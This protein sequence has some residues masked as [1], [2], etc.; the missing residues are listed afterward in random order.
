MSILSSV[1]RPSLVLLT[2]LYELTMA[3]GYW[4]EGMREQEATF[5][6]LFRTLPFEGGFAVACG[7]QQAVEFLQQL[8][9]GEDDLAYL[10]ELPGADGEPLFSAE[11]LAY[12]RELRFTCD[13]D[14]VPEGTVV[15]PQEPLI[16][17]RGPIIQA[18]IVETALLT[19][20]NFQT[21]IATKAAR[22]CLAAQ[23]DP[24][25]EFGLRRAQGVD[26][27]LS[28]SRAAFVGGCA[29]TSNLLAGKLFGIPVRGTHAHSWVMSFDSELEAFD[30]YA[31]ALP[32]NVVFL[33]DTY[34]TLE[35]V[36]HA[37][38]VGRRLRERGHE[39]LGIRLDSGDLAYLSKQ[40]RAILDEAGFAD[41]TILASSELDENIITSL[42]LQGATIAVWGVGTQLV[43]AY[44]QPA[45]GG[46]YKL[47][48][49]RNAGEPWEE[50]IKLSEQSIKITTPGILSVRRFSAGGEFIGDMIYDERFPPQGEA[51][52]VDPLDMT[53]RKHFPPDARCEELLVPAFRGGA[54]VYDA[55]PLEEVR[56]RAQEQ[57]AGFHEGVKRF[58]NPHRYPVGLEFELHQRR[59][60][61]I[62]AAR[63]EL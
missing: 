36:R 43:T 24:V 59:T 41:T 28:A 3:Y 17:V 40:A 15:F 46:V 27:G 29:A 1:Y 10:A 49:V 63:G 21:L 42:K 35:G 52:I 11:F 4:K 50:R 44:D 34:N 45:L 2:D 38:E 39:L 9:F 48:A 56:R 32:N 16:R 47:T 7:I 23:G 33:V 5:N 19:L 54:C 8:R 18:Q 51:T 25:L 53:R 26:G 30:A 6:L 58:V 12:L 13:V 31:R 55:P 37:V 20:I 61:L 22:V 14:V 57:L 62:L 60:A